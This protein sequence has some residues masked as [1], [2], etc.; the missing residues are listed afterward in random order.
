[1]STKLGV[2]QSTA[3]LPSKDTSNDEL[4]VPEV[5]P[6]RRGA[7]NNPNNLKP[8]GPQ[9]SE[10]LAAERAKASFDPSQLAVLLHGKENLEVDKMIL[11]V[12]ESEQVFSKENLHFMSREQRFQGA[13]ASGR[14]LLELAKEKGWNK[15]LVFRAMLLVDEPGPFSLHFS[16]F[17]PTLEGQCSNEQKAKWL[18]LALDNKII[19]CYAQTELGH[20]SNV[21]GL[22]TMATYVPETQEF[23]IHS[24]SLTASKWWIGGL[25]RTATHAIVVARLI[26]KGKDLGTHTFLVQIRSLEDHTPLP[27]ITIGDIGPK[28]GYNCVDN[29]FMLFD[30]V[31]V[32]R[33]SMLM[34][35]A[36]VEPDGTY[37]RPPSSKLS[38]GTMVFVRSS[39]VSNAAKNLARAATIATRYSAVRRQFSNEEASKEDVV[40]GEYNSKK[41]L[42]R[43]A[44]TAVID[45]PMQ[46]YRLLTQ[47]AKS[48]ALHFT[49]VSMME[50]YHQLVRDLSNGKIDG[51][52]EVHATSSG[53]KGLTTDMA[54]SGMEDLRRSCGGHGF[55]KNSGFP[56]FIADYLPNV[57]YEGDN[58]MLTQQT[59]RYLVKTFRSLKKMNATPINAPENITP[60]TRYL[61]DAA[62]PSFSAE[63]W[64]VKSA[65]DLENPSLLTAAFAHRAGQLVADLVRALDSG[66]LTWTTAQLDIYK[67][68]RAHCQYILVDNY[69]RALQSESIRSQ[70]PSIQ[71]LL[72]RLFTLF[73]LDT[74]ETE[75]GS[76]LSS[77]PTYINP[78]QISLIRQGVRSRVNALR[79]DAVALVDAW[80]FS[81]YVLNSDLGRADGRVYESL[82]ESAGR[83]PLNIGE[84]FPVVS[85][86][87]E[88]YAPLIKGSTAVRAKL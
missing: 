61:L 83:N 66:E 29:G 12:L 8:A 65:A 75:L 53:L 47:I 23:E 67:V 19:G 26:L 5:A 80:G 18:P 39:I 42:P 51:L 88:H 1:M 2:N 84:N 86:Y 40:A 44:E 41:L 34:R 72:H 57:T 58:Y 17:I 35:Y 4:I 52:P 49:G 16:M 70:P 82:V 87:A 33:E 68:S 55:L 81:D 28:Y 37:V 69:C 46:Q 73:T 77:S 7:W 60:T 63:T 30:R 15:D 22:E 31:R 38:Y 45:Y 62:Q 20:G 56:E 21:Q 71:L 11:D 78:T 27:G 10:S 48:Y 13:M 32:A 36:R 54:A 24:P 9:G 76:F 64:H 74:M 6:S 25:G 59:A 50:S 79:P 85:G 43:P 3:E 14:R